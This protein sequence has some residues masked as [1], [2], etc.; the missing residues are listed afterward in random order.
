[1]ENM[2]NPMEVIKEWVVN[3]ITGIFKEEQLD[4]FFFNGEVEVHRELIENTL[5]K[6]RS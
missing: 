5:D 3:G 6:L 1:M 2:K 4:C